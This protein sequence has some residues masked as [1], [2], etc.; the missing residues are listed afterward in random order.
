MTI[1]TAADAASDDLDD[2]DLLPE[3]RL[4]R[5]AARDVGA[6]RGGRARAPAGVPRRRPRRLR[7]RPRPPATGRRRPPLAAP[8]LGRAQ[9]HRVARGA[10]RAARQR[11]RRAVPLRA[12]LA[13][14]RVARAVPRARPRDAELARRVRCVPVAAVAPAPRCARGSAGRRGAARR[15]RHA[16]ALVDR[17]MHNRVRM[18]TASFLTKNLLIDWRRGEQWFWDTLV[19]ADAASNPFNWQWVA[20]SGRMPRRT[21]ACST[22]SCRRRSSTPTASTCAGGCPRSS[23]HRG[24]PRADRRPEA[25]ARC[26]ARRVRAGEGVALGPPALRARSRAPS[27]RRPGTAS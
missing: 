7:D 6:G 3:P 13:R 21:S 11:G 23:R 4:G 27:G 5:R 25:D 20:G 9:P 17:W 26:G 14:V 1:A 16:R 10:E 19:D 2:W 18:V 8:A 22:P 12:R 24:V 15:C